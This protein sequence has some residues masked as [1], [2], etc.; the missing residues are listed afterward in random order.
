MATP[1]AKWPM[2]WRNASAEPGTPYVRSDVASVLG[3]PSGQLAL[4]T[5]ALTQPGEQVVSPAF[6]LG[7]WDSGYKAVALAGPTS[8]A[9]H[10]GT[11]EK[12]TVGGDLSGVSTHRGNLLC[13]PRRSVDLNRNIGVVGHQGG[14]RAIGIKALESLQVTRVAQCLYAGKHSALAHRAPEHPSDGPWLGPGDG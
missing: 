7:K 12:G 5:S 10:L 11:G 4:V 13:Y 14:Q 8:V 3:N 1:E 6:A 2:T 9:E